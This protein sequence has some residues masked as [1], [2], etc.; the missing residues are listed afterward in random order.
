M[1]IYS[2]IFV[3]LSIV[4]IQ[5]DIDSHYHI[6]YVFLGI[7]IYLLAITGNI[8]YVFNYS[9]ETIKK[10]WKVISPVIV[11]YSISSCIIDKNFGAYKEKIDIIIWITVILILFPTFR[12]N[13]I[14]GYKKKYPPQSQGVV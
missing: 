6:G 8:C 7:I 3:F 4:S 13:F 1:L 2:V 5:D 14:L 12:A 10:F 9:N 11:A